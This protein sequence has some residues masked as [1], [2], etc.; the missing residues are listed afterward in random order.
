MGN[1]RG[2][3]AQAVERQPQVLWLPEDTPEG[4]LC[5]SPGSSGLRPLQP[6]DTPGQHPRCP[7]FRSSPASTTPPSPTPSQDLR[8]CPTK[9]RGRFLKLPP[10]SWASASAP[11][12]HTPS[13]EQP[14]LCALVSIALTATTRDAGTSVQRAQR[15][16]PRSPGSGMGRGP[17]EKPPNLWQQRARAPWPGLPSPTC[18]AAHLGASALTLPRSPAGWRSARS[19]LQPALLRMRLA[20]PHSQSATRPTARG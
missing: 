5:Q 18:S 9:P 7:G 4:A 1:G 20:A 12:A 15:A 19:T 14:L 17:S 6:E 3:A 11:A 2:K 16:P 13:S 8:L 10:Q